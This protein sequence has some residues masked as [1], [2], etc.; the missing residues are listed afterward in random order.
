MFNLIVYITDILPDCDEKSSP[1]VTTSS[2]TAAGDSAATTAASTEQ[3]SVAD[4]TTDVMTTISQAP[5]A[6]RLK[7]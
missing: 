1:S 3:P 4:V 6:L 7:K 5:G 2:A